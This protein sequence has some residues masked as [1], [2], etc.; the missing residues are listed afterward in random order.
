VTYPKILNELV[1]TKFKVVTGYPGGNEIALAMERGEVDGQCGISWGSVKTR[2]ASWLREG[3]LNLLAQF[4][5]T[6]ASDLANVPLAGEF[7][8]SERARKAIE[9]LESDTVLAW[10]LLAP[11][12]TP[13]ER[14]QELRRAFEAMLKDPELLADAAKQNLDVDLVPGDVLKKL[15]EDLYTTPDDV[16]QI[17]KRA[18]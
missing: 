8:R 14:V 18:M 1:G 11:P 13:A 3:K 7:A 12:G 6:R 2:L 15:V 4:A 16:I 5:V 10:P 9:F 17:V